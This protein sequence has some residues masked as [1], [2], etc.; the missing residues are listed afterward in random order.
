MKGLRK[1]LLCWLLSAGILLSCMPAGQAR[2]LSDVRGEDGNPAAES[3]SGGQ[4]ELI[5]TGSRIKVILDQTFGQD[6]S[7]EDIKRW[8]EALNRARG[9]SSDGTDV[10]SVI[11]QI[12][13]E[14]PEPEEKPKTPSSTSP[15]TVYSIFEDVSSEQYFF[16]AVLWA[17]ALGITNGTSPTTFSP[18][19]TCTRA[20]PSSGGPTA[21]PPTAAAIPSR[22]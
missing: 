15:P 8:E 3:L 4:P 16:D 10:G 9:T 22:T 5:Q 11:D 17:V 20:L 19:N 6:E 2:E 7:P 21:A 1:R 13:E 18:G 14:S 12:I